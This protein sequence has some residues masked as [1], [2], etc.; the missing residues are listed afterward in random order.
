[1]ANPTPYRMLPGE[2]RV[3]LLTHAISTRREFRLLYIQRL[4]ALPGGFRPVT[5]QTWPAEKL[6]K[7]VVRRKAEKADD[8]ADL[9]HHLYVELDPSIQSSFLDAT[10]VRHEAGKIDEELEVPYTD[11]D[12]VRRGAAAVRERHGANGEHY[13]RT[14]ARYNGEAWPGIDEVV[15]E[16]PAAAS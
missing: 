14:I 8:E 2:R 11:A 6:A 13:L 15:A 16:L 1:M 12:S 9:L 5:L 10:G 4:A 3:A 7:E